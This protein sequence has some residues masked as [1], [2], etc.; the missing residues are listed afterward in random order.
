MKNSPGAVADSSAFNGLLFV[1]AGI[2][3]N[4]RDQVQIH[5][6]HRGQ[7]WCIKSCDALEARTWLG[8]DAERLV[9]WDPS[10]VEDDGL[11]GLYRKASFHTPAWIVHWEEIKDLDGVE[12]REKMAAILGEPLGTEEAKEEYVD[13]DDA[14]DKQVWFCEA[15]HTVGC[16]ELEAHTDVYSAVKAIERSH[17]QAS[18]TCHVPVRQLRVM[19]TAINPSKE[20]LV[21]DT[22]IPEWVREPA[23]QFLGL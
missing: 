11:S 16:T 15:C 14:T 5:V 8:E 23:A 10:S 20:A 2:N 4:N 13:G 21:A 1:A 17:R 7:T 9:R 12:D 19:N 6:L 18:S 3:P 22:S